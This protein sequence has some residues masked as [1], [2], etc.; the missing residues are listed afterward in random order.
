MGVT[1]GSCSPGTNETL[2]GYPLTASAFYYPDRQSLGAKC[3]DLKQQIKK[4]K[5]W[6]W[7]NKNC[8]SSFY[9]Y[10]TG[11][12]YPNH[13]I[14]FYSHLG[15][16][17]ALLNIQEHCFSGKGASSLVPPID[18]QPLCQSSLLKEITKHSSGFDKFPRLRVQQL[19][20]IR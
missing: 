6:P 15:P 8:L 1:G 5:N 11:Q 19:E 20:A 2:S 7:V 17:P 9:F 16:L 13:P 10:N 12:A 18:W 4:E 14:Q 3:I